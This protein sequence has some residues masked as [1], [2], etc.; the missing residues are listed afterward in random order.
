MNKY[1]PSQTISQ[2]TYTLMVSTL[3]V[4]TCIVLFMIAKEIYNYFKNK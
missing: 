3:C 2:A 1:I 4:L